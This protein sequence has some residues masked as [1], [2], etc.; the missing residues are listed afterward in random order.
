MSE[1][2]EYY[3]TVGHDDIDMLGHVNNVVYV[4]W[5]QDSALAHSAAVGWSTE[6][7]LQFGFGWVVRWHHINYLRPC[8]ADDRIIVRTWVSSMKRVMSERRY[9][10]FRV[11]EGGKE[12]V[13]TAETRWGFIKYSTGCPARIPPE[14]QEALIAVD[15]ELDY[16]PENDSG[17]SDK[18]A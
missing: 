9:Q 11:I 13:A 15:R 18:A 4:R 3:L 1:I 14:I 6:R 7:H 2:F 5:L 17:D 12:L 16:L 8:L 10:I